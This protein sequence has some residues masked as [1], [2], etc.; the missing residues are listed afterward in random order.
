M[1]W[2]SGE[3]SVISMMNLMKIR[4]CSFRNIRDKMRE[5]E[6]FM[7]ELYDNNK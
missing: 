7:R 6:E 2:E 4:G 1:C 5:V 3:M